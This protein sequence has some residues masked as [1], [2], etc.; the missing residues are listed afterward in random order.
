M[1]EVQN[2]F[3]KYRIKSLLE[4]IKPYCAMGRKL[5]NWGIGIKL[6]RWRELFGLHRSKKISFINCNHLTKNIV[7]VCTYF[8]AVYNLRF[9]C[10]LIYYRSFCFLASSFSCH[11][12]AHIEQWVL[13]LSGGFH[14][15]DPGFCLKFCAVDLLLV[16]FQHAEM[17]INI[18]KRLIHGRYN[19]MRV[20]VEPET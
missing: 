9:G 8:Y 5:E 16:Y 2:C 19:V 7:S 12:G 3:W 14:F 6:W 4:T 13:I 11:G 10:M 1:Q 17:P 18:V 20:R 15:Q